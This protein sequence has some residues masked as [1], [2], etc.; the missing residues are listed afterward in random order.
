MKKLIF[1][2]GLLLSGCQGKTPDLSQLVV[3]SEDGILLDYEIIPADSEE[4]DNKF[5]NYVF[6]RPSGRRLYAPEL[7]DKRWL[8]HY[9]ILEAQ[10]GDPIDDFSIDDI[11]P[12]FGMF[13]YRVHPTTL[14]AKYHHTAVDIFRDVGTPIYAVDDGEVQIHNDELGGNWVQI[15][16][17]ITTKDGYHLETRYLHLEEIQEGLED[18]D[19]VEG[20]VQIGTLGG[21][22]I[23]NGYFPHLHFEVVMVNDDRPDFSITLDPARIYFEP[24][25]S[26]GIGCLMGPSEDSYF[27]NLTGEIYDYEPVPEVLSTQINENFSDEEKRF[28][29]LYVE[30]WSNEGDKKAH[31]KL[32]ELIEDDTDQ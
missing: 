26:G 16:H 32:L 10:F 23:M 27:R 29:P 18:G 21:T 15:I 4:R 9:D 31:E 17:P 14:K 2:A 8:A 11:D 7:S 24:E 13:G 28:L 20:R 19:T 25:K 3:E 5:E 6:T 22:G 30:Y 12:M 1:T